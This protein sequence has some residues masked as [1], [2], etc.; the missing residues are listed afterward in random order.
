MLELAP[1][2]EECWVD[3]ALHELLVAEFCVAVFGRAV[4]AHDEVRN[5]DGLVES[6]VDDFDDALDIDALLGIDAE[7]L[8]RDIKLSLADKILSPFEKAQF[9]AAEDKKKALLT[10]WVLKEA[11]AKLTGRG[12]GNYLRQTDF[13]PETV[14]IIDGCYVAVLEG[15]NHAF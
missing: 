9:D 7:E 8:S 13:D 10:F 14:Q 5:A 3:S 1:E 6:V 12:L 4:V 11:Y 2:A 15:E